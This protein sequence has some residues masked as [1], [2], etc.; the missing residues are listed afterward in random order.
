LYDAAPA[1]ECSSITSNEEEVRDLQL[2]VAIVDDVVC[3]V[4]ERLSV[5]EVEFL[6][7]E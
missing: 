2:R 7:G 3:L 5:D 1:R 6:V 4:M